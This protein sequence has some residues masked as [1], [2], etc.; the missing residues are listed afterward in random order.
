ML[1]LTTLLLLLFGF[2]GCSDK[3][4]EFSAN[5]C[6]GFPAFVKNAGYPPSTSFFSTSNERV[7]GLQLMQAQ[8]PGQPNSR[9][10]KTYQHPSWRK[11]GWLAPIL[12]DEVGNIYSSPA[13]FI[14]ILD[15]PINNNNTIYRV[16]AATGVMEEFLKLPFA[17]SVNTQNPFGI[18]GMVYLCESKTLYVSSLAGSRRHQEKGHIYAIDIKSKKIIDKI[19]NTDAMGMGISYLT[20]ERRLYF[21]TGRGSVVYSIRLNANGKF[22]GKPRAE[23][24]LQNLGPAG[25][26]RVRRIQSDQFGNLLVHGILFNY[27]LIPAREKKETVYTFSYNQDSSKWVLVNFR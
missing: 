19:N 8:F 18:I 25:D 2:Y 6:K 16:D 1:R 17:D 9:I 13:P 4:V 20:G 26:D 3:E 7:M 12:L 22:S 5:N 23:F 27:N 10:V 14:S 24:S 21:G 11:G 15:N